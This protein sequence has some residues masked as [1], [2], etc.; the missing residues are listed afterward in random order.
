MTCLIVINLSQYGGIVQWLNSGFEAAFFK[1]KEMSGTQNEPQPSYIN[2]RSTP[3]YYEGVLSR[4][5]VAFLIDCFFIYGP[6]VLLAFFIFILGIVT[7]GL[8]WLLF[9]LLSPIFVIW[10]LLYTAT[11]LGGKHS[12]TI[13]M[14]MMDLE[15]RTMYGGKM[16]FLLASLH[17]VLFYISIVAFTPVVLVIALMNPGR[18]LAHDFLTGAVLVNNEE[19]AARLRRN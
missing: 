8:G 1:V 18:R 11:T 17:I 16:D 3:E 13:G 6:V 10:A 19:R 14:R 2:P 4:R 12:A 5:I 7:L 15:M 9:W